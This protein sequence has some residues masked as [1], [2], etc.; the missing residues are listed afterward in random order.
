MKTKPIIINDDP[1]NWLDEGYADNRMGS[2]VKGY[3]YKGYWLAPDSNLKD[4][5][6]YI[7]ECLEGEV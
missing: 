7:N 3:D 6:T 1:K 5:I 4:A 2:Y